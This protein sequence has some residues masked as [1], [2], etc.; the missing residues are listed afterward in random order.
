MERSF[1]KMVI[2]ST[3]RLNCVFQPTTFCIMKLS[4]ITYISR[5]HRGVA[6][7]ASHWGASSTTVI[8]LS[9]SA[10]GS[11]GCLPDG[12]RHIHVRPNLHKHLGWIG[13]LVGRIGA[14]AQFLGIARQAK[15]QR[16]HRSQSRSHG[17]CLAGWHAGSQKEYSSTTAMNSREIATQAHNLADGLHWY[18]ATS[19]KPQINSYAD[20]LT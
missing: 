9:S 15:K 12:I 1:I 13:R 10:E 20:R 4:D 17:D 3:E 7:V 16:L 11:I 2:K 8:S 18:G 19:D 5:V 14:V 6:A